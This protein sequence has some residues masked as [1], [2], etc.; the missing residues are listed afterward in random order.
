M[1]D[2]VIVTGAG[3]GIGRATSLLLAENSFNIISV[4]KSEDDMVSLHEEITKKGAR[5]ISIVCDVS[6]YN[7]LITKFRNSIGKSMRIRA[8]IINAGFGEWYSASQTPVEEWKGMVGT[9]LDGAYNAFHAIYNG[10]ELTDD[11]QL[12]AISSDSA[13]YPYANRAAYCTSKAALSMF[14]QCTREELR[15]KKYRVT[16]IVPSRVDTHFRKKT[17][18]ARLDCLM[19]YDIASLILLVLEMKKDIEL[20]RV[21]LSSINSSFGK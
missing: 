20:R 15:K 4:S 11:F 3:K 6:D 14:M 9:N 7:D 1:Y 21:D 16:E 17:P 10:F 5:N 8:L 2:Y 12:V 19:P 18:G 13:Y